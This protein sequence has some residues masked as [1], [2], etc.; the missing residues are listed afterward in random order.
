MKNSYIYEIFLKSSNINIEVWDNY[1]KIVGKFLGFFSNFKVLVK[2]EYNKVRYFLIVKRCLPNSFNNNNFLIKKSDE[3]FDIEAQFKG[4]KFC[5]ENNNILNWINYFYKKNS[6]VKIFLLSLKYFQDKIRTKTYVFYKYNN[7]FFYKRIFGGIAS[8]FLSIDFSLNKSLFFSNCPKYLKIDKILH[9]LT[10]NQDGANFLVDTFPYLSDNFY[11]R[12]DSYDFYKHSLV[13]GSSGSGKSKFLASLIT[14]ICKEKNN[15]YKIVVI[16]PH[17]ALKK[18]LWQIPNLEIIDFKSENSSIELF[19]SNISDINANVELTLSLFKTLIDNYNSKLERVLRFCTYI[20]VYDNSFS[21]INLRKLLLELNYR[22]LLVNKLK[23]VLA[24]SI[25]S[26]F[27]N[28]FNEIKN[29]HYSEAIAPIIAFIDEMQMI[30]VFNL[31]QQTSDV[32]SKLKKNVLTIFSLNRLNLGDKVTKTIAGFLLQQIFL[33]AESGNLKE[34]LIV[35]ID[36]VS[37]LE[38]PI[39]ARF[40]AELRKFNVSVIL[41][42]QYFHQISENLKEAILANTSNYYL[43]KVSKT[44][45]I[46]LNDNLDIKLEDSDN[47]ED[48]TNFLTNLKARECLVRI[49]KN[50]TSYPMFKARTTDFIVPKYEEKKL[51]LKKDILK[52]KKFEFDFETSDVD[53]HEIMK[54]VSTSKREDIK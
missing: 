11:L 13:I 17:D 24:P 1:L 48:K 34:H 51:V 53:I 46:I 15:K 14:N 6:E 3:V 42:C 54:N 16:D 47:R 4:F 31:E 7:K 21:F 23:D 9:L 36:E 49:S 30:P 22:N 18:E 19:K 2:V 44:D 25:L 52:E 29:Q 39:L 32:F 35:V 37:V 8:K 20:L 43:F 41:A 38:N 33:I 28:D 26:F 27:L 45:A 10:T 40:L 5:L 50:R 12:Y